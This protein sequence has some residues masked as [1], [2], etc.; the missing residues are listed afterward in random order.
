MQRPRATG[1]EDIGP[2]GGHGKESNARH[3]AV[4]SKSLNR[5]FHQGQSKGLS[6]YCVLIN[7][8]NFPDTPQ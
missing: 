6:A 1:A 2:K 4:C 3:K 7:P 5:F 8:Q